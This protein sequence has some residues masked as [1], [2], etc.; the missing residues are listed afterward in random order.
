MIESD[1]NFIKKGLSI[2][3][4]ASIIG[5]YFLRVGFSTAG[6]IFSIICC[7]VAY[8]AN[9]ANR[10]MQSLFIGAIIGLGASYATNYYFL[11]ILSKRQYIF[12]IELLIPSIVGA[13]PGILINYGINKFKKKD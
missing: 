8:Y 4:L 3:A 13:I 7:A 2:I 1:K 10:G 12:N 6:L 5:P 9:S 11:N